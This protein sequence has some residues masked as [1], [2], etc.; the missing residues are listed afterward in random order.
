MKEIPLLLQI[1]S[2]TSILYANNAFSHLFFQSRAKS[3]LFPTWVPQLPWYTEKANFSS[4][5]AHFFALVQPWKILI[6]YLHFCSQLNSK[7]LTKYNSCY[8]LL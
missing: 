5:S 4:T 6:S 2:A 1:L 3:T 8:S 7:F